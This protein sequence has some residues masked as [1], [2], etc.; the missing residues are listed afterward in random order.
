MTA[1]DGWLYAVERDG[2]L[3]DAVFLIRAEEGAYTPVAIDEKGRVY[4]EN[5]GFVVVAGQT[6]ANPN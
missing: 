4:A 3:R 6:S 5:S 2:S 1:A